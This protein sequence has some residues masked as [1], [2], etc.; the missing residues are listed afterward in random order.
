MTPLT[1][2]TL[3]RAFEPGAGASA[4][5]VA[6]LAGSV[7]A[8][9]FRH[10]RGSDGRRHLFSVFPIGS[11][12]ALDEVPRFEDAVVLAVARDAGG[13]RQILLADETGPLPDLFFA[14]AGLGRAI[15]AGANEVHVHLLTDSAAGRAALLRDLVRG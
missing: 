10:W 2:N 5:A 4:S 3:S 14:G 15:A 1:E 9:R 7:L 12:D 8:G 11:G 13:G 6:G